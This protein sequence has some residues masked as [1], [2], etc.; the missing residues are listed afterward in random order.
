MAVA[1]PDAMLARDGMRR[2]DQQ[3][4]ERK[5]FMK[6]RVDAFFRCEIPPGKPEVD[7]VYP[8][9]PT[10]FQAKEEAD[11]PA[12]F[13]HVSL[14]ERIGPTLA[15]NT[16]PGEPVDQGVIRKG[17]AF[18]AVVDLAVDVLAPDAGRQFLFVLVVEDE[19]D[20]DVLV[21]SCSESVQVAGRDDLFQPDIEKEIEIGRYDVDIIT[22]DSIRLIADFVDLFK[23]TCDP[24]GVSASIGVAIV[25]VC[26]IGGI[27]KRHIF[28]YDGPVGESLFERGIGD[29]VTSMIERLSLLQGNGQRVDAGIEILG[30]QGI[31]HMAGNI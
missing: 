20:I 10:A 29:Q 8:D 9:R 11:I 5:P 27:G 13:G 31:E 3:L 14:R 30:M 16:G 26:R 7:V 25:I 23:G 19:M 4:D 12:I 28:P 18:E 21:D 2:R 1:Q 15:V 17:E 24:D 22:Q 6:K